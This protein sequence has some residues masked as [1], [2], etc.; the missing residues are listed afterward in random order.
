MLCLTVPTDPAWASNALRDEAA[1]LIDHA[2]CEIK[3]AS[4]ALSLA[5]R[6]S[7]DLAL[8][9]ALADIAGEEIAHFKRVLSLL[10]ARGLALGPASVD[11]YALRSPAS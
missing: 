4:N 2:H 1:L 10:A 3:A 5:G 9:H 7:N 6:H 11:A 8:T